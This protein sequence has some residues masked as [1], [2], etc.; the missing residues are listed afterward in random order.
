MRQMSR[1]ETMDLTEHMIKLFS[2]LASIWV[3]ISKITTMKTEEKFVNELNL[4]IMFNSFW[5]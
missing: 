5:I 2:L 1:I 3:K 4:F